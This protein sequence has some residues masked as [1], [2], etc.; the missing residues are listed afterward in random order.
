MKARFHVVL[1]A[2]EAGGGGI[3][4]PGVAKVCFVACGTRGG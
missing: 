1:R 4:V 3:G 2:R